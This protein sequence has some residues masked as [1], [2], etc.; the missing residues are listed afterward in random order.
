MDFFKI[1]TK[2]LTLVHFCSLHG[3]DG[4]YGWVLGFLDDS[5]KD[6][7][8]DIQLW[9]W[10]DRRQEVISQ[11][12]TLFTNQRGQGASG[13]PHPL[14]EQNLTQQT[15]LSTS[16][17]GFWSVQTVKWGPGVS[18]NACAEPSPGYREKQAEPHLL[19]LPPTV[20]P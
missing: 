4:W 15:W 12:H 10:L 9:P 18:V 17:Q 1:K 11:R 16:S 13:H 3:T 5:R 20:L 14:P 8:L 6:R 2:T 19:L 7:T